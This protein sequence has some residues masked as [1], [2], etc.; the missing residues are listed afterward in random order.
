M[1]QQIQLRRG[2]AAQWTATNPILAAG[3]IGVELDTGKFKT[4][5]GATAWAS[6]PYVDAGA[7]A[8]IAN[9]TGAHAA[10]AVSVSSI[11]ALGNPADVQAA[12]AAIPSRYVQVASATT[13][14]VLTQAAYDAIGSPSSTTL[15]VIVG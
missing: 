7:A 5:D 13:L 9:A 10:S 14:S 1:A 4:G 15:Y 12:L 3:E 11:P 6:R 2:S 8:H